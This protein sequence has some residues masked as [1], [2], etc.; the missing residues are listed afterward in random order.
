MTATI[1]LIDDDVHLVQMLKSSL[2]GE[3]YHVLTGFD[4]QMAVNLATTRKPHLIIMDV[5]M[6]MTNGLKALEFLR[7]TPATTQIPVIFLSG[8]KSGT[9]YPVIESV[10][11]VAFLKK[12]LD[13]EHLLSM[14]RQYL[15]LYK[16]A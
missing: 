6:P 3:G 10:Q 2:E 11:R 13:I 1:L 16:A 4:G 14:I 7:K 12:P 8:E 15:Q 5:N 9:I